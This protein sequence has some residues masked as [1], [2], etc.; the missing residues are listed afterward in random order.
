VGRYDYKYDH[1]SGAMEPEPGHTI[2]H[3]IGDVIIGFEELDDTIS[4]A[5]S[6]IL[7]RG[8]DIG[9]IVTS[10]LSF[11]SKVDM[12]GALI[13]HDRPN[14]T[15]AKLIDDL[16]VGCVSI[17]E[18]RNKIVHSKWRRDFELPGIQRSKFTARA[19]HGLKETNEMWHPGHFI[20]VWVHCGYLAHEIDGWMWAEYGRQYAPDALEDDPPRCEPYERGVP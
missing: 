6:G 14:S 12:F 13:K 10:Q 1:D 20:S 7:N 8:E 15:L 3:A 17:E 19:K 16:C 18:E 2:E 5:I 9:R 4:G 11:R